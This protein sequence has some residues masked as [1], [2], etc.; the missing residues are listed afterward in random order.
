MSYI[1]GLVSTIIPTYKRSEKL[2]RAIRSA[3]E[4]SYRNVEVLVVSDNE[5]DDEY[6]AEAQR[7]VD[8]FNDDRVKLIT[9]EH[10]K[11]GAAARNAGIKAAKGEYIAF[12]DDDDYWERRK[13]ELQVELLSSLDESWGAVTCKNK[14][15]VN[16]NL[17]AAQT[18]IKDGWICRGI[19]SRTTHVSTDTILL[20]HVALDESGYFDE[21]LRRHQEV[22]MMGMF[23][24]K[25]KI[26]LLDLYLVC[27]DSSANENQP[28]ADKMSIIKKEFIQA[29]QPVL[30]KLPKK[31]VKY[32]KTMNQFELGGLYFK[33]G[34]KKKGIKLMLGILKSPGTVFSATNLLIRK[35][36]CKF[37]AKRR[38]RRD[39]YTT[40]EKMPMV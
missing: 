30:D 32:I 21:N 19:L 23:A 11:N 29:V 33:T 4:Q 10:H 27:V 13:I 36:A 37:F 14:A 3:L 20:R 40:M 17:V 25:Y 7:V 12:L 39:G 15:Y 6:T 26:K 38:V 5:P 35:F 22:Q 1:S 31:D 8:S 34:H 18:P 2:E 9:Q 16:G 28:N 24:H